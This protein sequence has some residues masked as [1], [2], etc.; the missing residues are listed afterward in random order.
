M[1]VLGTGPGGICLATSTAFTACTCNRC[2]CTVCRCAGFC[3]RVLIAGC[4]QQYCNKWR[5]GFFHKEYLIICAPGSTV[6]DLV[7]VL[8]GDA[9]LLLLFCPHAASKRAGKNKEMILFMLY[10]LC[11]I[12]LAVSHSLLSAAGIN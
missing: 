1:T 9:V 12:Y 10:D 11:V 4:K 8:P 3:I 5:D 7:L 2:V 6:D